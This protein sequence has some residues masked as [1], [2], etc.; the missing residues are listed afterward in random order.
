MG[1]YDAQIA[2]A[3]RLIKKF[4]EQVTVRNLMEPSAAGAQPWKPV[5]GVP[6]QVDTPLQDFVVL[7]L[8]RDGREAIRYADGSDVKAGD[9]SFM[10]P[11]SVPVRLG[12]LIIRASGQVWKVMSLQPLDV[13]GSVISYE[14]VLSQ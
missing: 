1:Q 2:L 14:G 11:A 6:A 8:Q 10:A 9:K 4:G 13:G 7:P 3:S 5:A 12:S